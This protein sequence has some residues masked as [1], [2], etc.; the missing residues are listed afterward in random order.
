ML[1]RTGDLDKQ[2]DYR[3]HRSVTWMSDQRCITKDVGHLF[4]KQAI[5]MAWDYPRGESVRQYRRELSTRYSSNSTM[6][7]G[8]IA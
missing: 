6:G 7:I 4:T 1:P 5:P 2:A 8:T 3:E